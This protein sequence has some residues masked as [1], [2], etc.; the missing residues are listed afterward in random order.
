[1][2]IAQTLIAGA[3]MYERKS[4]RIDFA[5][6][7]ASHEVTLVAPDSLAQSTAQLLHVY[8]PDPLPSAP[9]VG[10]PIPFV[11][12]GS[13]AE[14]R[15]AFRRPPAPRAQLS[16]LDSLPEAVE[17]HWWETAASGNSE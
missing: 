16:P 8:G 10:L 17:E 9:F 7:S 1:M 3:S 4:Q 6:L 11:A 5:A 14:R 2:R 13:V 12:A 15:L